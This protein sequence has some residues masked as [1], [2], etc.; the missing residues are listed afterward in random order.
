V[1]KF[2]EAPVV[3]TT[4]LYLC[5]WETGFT[6]RLHSI[7]GEKD[8]LRY[9]PRTSPPSL[10]TVEKYIAHHLEH[11]QIYGYGHWA[12]I[13]RPGEEVIGWC[14]LEYLPETEETEVAY[15]LSREY[16]GRGYATEAADAA[17]LFGF[18]STPLT[19]IIGLAHPDNIASRRVLEKCGLTYIDRKIYFLMELCR[20]RIEF[21]G[22]KAS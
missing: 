18:T 16:W 5:P 7:L 11:W 22:K 10:E 21:P 14:G 20:Y 17:I 12:V 19:E 13:S 1:D 6:S 9:F 4:H 2:V 8:I 3:V 15:L